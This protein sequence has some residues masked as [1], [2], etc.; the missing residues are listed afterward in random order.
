MLWQPFL[1]KKDNLNRPEFASL[2]MQFRVFKATHKEENLLSRE[3]ILSFMSSLCKKGD[4]IK[5]QDTS[6]FPWRIIL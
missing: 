1:Y 3:Q 4:K 6:Y 5:N 2:G